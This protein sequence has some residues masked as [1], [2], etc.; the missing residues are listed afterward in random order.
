MDPSEFKRDNDW[1]YGFSAEQRGV[2]WQLYIE[3]ADAG[4]GIDYLP[5]ELSV[6]CKSSIDIIKDIVDKK[7]YLVKYKGRN[8]KNKPLQI[9]HKAIDLKIKEAKKRVSD[10][11]KAINKRWQK[12]TPVLRGEQRENYQENILYNNRQYFL[13][14]IYKKKAKGL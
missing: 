3:I 1:V 9:R 13:K 5:E 6:R 2:Y 10:A 11:K 4:G 8:S 12:D 14:K 7:F